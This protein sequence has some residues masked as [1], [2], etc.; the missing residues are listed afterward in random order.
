MVVGQVAGTAVGAVTAGEAVIS[1]GFA[2]EGAN[3][4]ELSVR[5]GR[6]AEGVCPHKGT[7]PA[8]EALGQGLTGQASFRALRCSSEVAFEVSL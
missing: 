5:A 7:I 8:V 1:A 2:G 6:I 4:S 3:V